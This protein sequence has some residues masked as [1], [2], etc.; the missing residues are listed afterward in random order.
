M[1]CSCPSLSVL[2]VLRVRVSEV[3]FV[4]VLCVCLRVCLFA[5]MEL[6]SCAADRSACAP[7]QA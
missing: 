2:C 3:L 4:S 6:W 5:L 7:A 1:S